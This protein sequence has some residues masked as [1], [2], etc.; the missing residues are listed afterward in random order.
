ERVEAE[1]AAIV[2]LLEPSAI[3][4][5]PETPWAPIE[6]PA[7][8]LMA[9]PYQRHLAYELDPAEAAPPPSAY[10]PPSQAVLMAN[11][12]AAANEAARA[13]PNPDPSGAAGAE[14]TMTKD[15]TWWLNT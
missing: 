5:L 6:E 11:A 13:H 3:A 14:A 10:R 2:P 8:A 12:A 1:R 9:R 7:P 15:S 4:S